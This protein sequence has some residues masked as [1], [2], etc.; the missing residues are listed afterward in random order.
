MFRCDKIAVKFETE[1]QHSYVIFLVKD[2]RSQL[3]SFQFVISHFRRTRLEIDWQW[4]LHGQY[5]M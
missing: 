2:I 4:T 3:G 1:L 5:V